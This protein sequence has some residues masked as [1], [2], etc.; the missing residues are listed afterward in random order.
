M[1]SLPLPDPEAQLL[2][3]VVAVR[4]ARDGVGNLT[5]TD[6]SALRLADARGSVDALRAVGWQVDDVLLDGD[7]TAPVAVT[8][9]DL[10]P[11]ADHP[12]PF[13]KTMRSRVSGWTTRTLTAKPLK[14]LPPTA[15]L[16]GLFLAAH[17]TNRLSGRI[18]PDLP[19]ACRAAVPDL[20]HKGFLTALSEDRYSL[21]PLVRHLS[22]MRP[23]TDEEKGVPPLSPSPRFDV[24]AWKRWKDSATP[25]LRRHVEA[26]ESCA[27][28]ALATERVAEA[29]TVPPGS[30]AISHHTAKLY[31]RWKESHP[32]RG[33]LAAGFTVAFRAEHGH[34]P[35]HSQLCASLGW[36]PQ[37]LPRHSQRM[38]SLFIVQ[39]L[40][41]NE[42]LTATSP[43]PWTLR[44]GK[45]AQAH[46]I[47]LP[48][49]PAVAPVAPRGPADGRQAGQHP[50]R[51]VQAGR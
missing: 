32:A 13:G 33:P 21:D 46:G 16:T 5:G 35:S 23:R 43:V 38:L 17:S 22:G 19:S 12:L 50:A 30:L 15:R 2:A 28:C 34:G 36:N 10:A 31:G 41:A 25:A 9:P 3:V 11:R 47:A 49:T 40:L 48:R 42:W 37:S 14:K 39:R 29:F 24:D 45:T 18:P 6:V 7:P 1:S 20:L 44:P 27:L 8:V 26:V 51:C 4:A